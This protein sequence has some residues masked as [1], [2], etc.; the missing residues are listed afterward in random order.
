M[1]E[2]TPAVRPA[3]P[4]PIAI[5]LQLLRLMGM[6]TLTVYAWKLLIFVA[7]HYATIEAGERSALQALSDWMLSWK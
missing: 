6:L 1:G 4:L 7:M 2:R 3:L 5:V